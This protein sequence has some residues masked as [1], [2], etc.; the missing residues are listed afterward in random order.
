MKSSTA[1]DYKAGLFVNDFVLETDSP[2]AEGINAGTY[3]Q[4]IVVTGR[5][6]ISTLGLSN[7]Q[8]G[9]KLSL[10]IF[11]RQAAPTT[12]LSAAYFKPDQ[13]VRVI[14]HAHLVCLGIAHSNF[15][16]TPVGGQPR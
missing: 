1:G 9:L 5:R 11:V 16:R 13:I 4:N 15:S 14:N 2:L 6:E 12:K 8:I 3:D 10:K 7:G